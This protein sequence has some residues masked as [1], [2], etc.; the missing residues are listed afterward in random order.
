MKKRWL[1]LGLAAIMSMGVFAA[2]GDKDG[3]QNGDGGNG[4]GGEIKGQQVTQEQWEN[5]FI[6]VDFSKVI[7]EGSGMET[8]GDTVY[9]YT[10]KEVY[11]P[12]MYYAEYTET[13]TDGTRTE[14]EGGGDWGVKADNG[15]YYTFDADKV[16]GAFDFNDEEW[17][18][19]F[20]EENMTVDFGYWEYAWENI[21][22]GDEL[23]N[24]DMTAFTYD[25]E[26]GVYYKEKSATVEGSTRNARVEILI[27][28]GKLYSLKVDATA[29]GEYNGNESMQY[30]FAEGTITL[31]K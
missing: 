29:T 13:M 3:D 15:L 14:S 4:G 19:H 8:D 16:D 24:Q 6:N 30:T 25:S 12:N 10:Q 17:D 11:L 2:C 5:V 23:I 26:K 31:P 18:A 28:N 1:L 7:R 22:E 20:N 27:S 21:F 9:T